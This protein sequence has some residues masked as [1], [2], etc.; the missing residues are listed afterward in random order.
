M[1]K[2]EKPEPVHAVFFGNAQVQEAVGQSRYTKRQE[3]EEG[4]SEQGTAAQEL[5]ETCDDLKAEVIKL[6]QQ[7]SRMNQQWSE[8]EARWR[9]AEKHQRQERERLIR[10]VLLLKQEWDVSRHEH[11]HH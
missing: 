5:A 4:A 7:L 9:E 6:K 8:L 11:R 10:M 3:S 1:E 2:R